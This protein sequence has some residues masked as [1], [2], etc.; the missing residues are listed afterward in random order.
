MQRAVFVFMLS[1]LLSS[2][3]L[4]AGSVRIHG[5]IA[6]PL[7]GQITFSTYDGML[8]YS[9]V[10]RTANLDKYGNFSLVFPITADY[11]DISLQ[12]GDQASELFLRDGDDVTMSLDAKDFDKTLRYSGKG[13]AT[14]NFAAM[15]VLDN[16]LG[17]QFGA[18]LQPLMAKGP[19][20]FMSASKDMLQKELDYLQ[21]HK[22]G[23]PA[24]FIKNWTAKL[25]YTMYYDW[26]IYPAYHQMMTKKEHP[27]Q[28]IPKENYQVSASIPMVFD[29]SYLSI[30][31]YRNLV[32]SIFDNRTG[33]LDS[34]HAKLYRQN[35]SAAILARKW[36]PAKSREFYFA[37]KVYGEMDYASVSKADSDYYAFKKMYPGSHYMPVLDKAV[38][39]K[40]KLGAGQ[41]ALDF[42]F[43]SLDGRKMK[44]SDLRGK[45]VLLDFWASWCGPCMQELPSTKKVEEHFK[46]RDVVFLNVS[47]DDDT[48][49]WKK[50]IEKKQIE[51]INVC[52]PG[53][54][55]S[56]IAAKYGVQGVPV[57]F[58]IDKQ[59][60]F[61]TET[62]PRPSETD[63]LTD[64]IEQALH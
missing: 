9:E 53:G 62:T 17:Q 58:L 15:H 35:D 26:L 20:E 33:G 49:A 23:L 48:T 8:E 31:S 25:S 2:N 50:A 19:E 29:D 14:A 51:G 60:R 46:G 38:K 59:G 13:A 3:A 27:L 64:L 7:S 39:L 11:M 1:Q 47:I 21:S 10:Q 61:V 41:P 12:H 18:N 55:K 6:N 28:E 5:K 45:V 40:R 16:G 63:K 52:Q 30:S 4:Y 37:H 57:Y 32:G 42:A 43:T 34:L 54:W 56:P 22:D 44:L 24:A 36:L